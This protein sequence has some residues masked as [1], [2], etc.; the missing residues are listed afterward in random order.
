MDDTG[1]PTRLIVYSSSKPVRIAMSMLGSNAPK[2][3]TI[4]A[5]FRSML[6]A[7]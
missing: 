6:K 4:I 3:Q 1:S 7:S 2:E 5:A